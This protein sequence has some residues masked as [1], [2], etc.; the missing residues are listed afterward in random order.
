MMKCKDHNSAAVCCKH[1]IGVIY[2]CQY[3]HYF[4]ESPLDLSIIL[5]N[6]LAPCLT[7]SFHHVPTLPSQQSL[8][9]ESVIVF[10]ICL[11]SRLRP[12]S[13][14]CSLLITTLSPTSH[15]L[16]LYPK[17]GNPTTPW[18]PA[19]SHPS[20]GLSPKHRARGQEDSSRA[21][22]SMVS[23]EAAEAEA[24]GLLHGTSL[25]VL[26]ASFR[27]ADRQVINVATL[28]L[29]AAC[30]RPAWIWGSGHIMGTVCPQPWRQAQGYSEKVWQVEESRSVFQS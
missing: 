1:S 13:A 14:L 8:S 19:L 17:T 21:K 15:Q 30:T 28:A 26:L 7:T 20:Y 2:Y 24:S 3:Y 5:L 27:E 12:R 16:T 25:R 23:A 11:L 4:S 18:S 22:S 9:L 6:F 29:M 10:R